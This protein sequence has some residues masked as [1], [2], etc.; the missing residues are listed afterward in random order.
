MTRSRPASSASRSS[1]LSDPFTTAG[2]AG[3]VCAMNALQPNVKCHCAG[4]TI[5]S[6]SAPSARRRPAMCDAEEGAT[7]GSSGGACDGCN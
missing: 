1:I 7:G 5:R 2:P 6:G 4:G 3:R